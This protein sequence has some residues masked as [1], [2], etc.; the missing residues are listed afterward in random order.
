MLK[1]PD[2]EKWLTTVKLE[3]D[4]L[5]KMG[6]Y[7]VVDSD[8]IHLDVPMW[9]V[10]KIKRLLINKVKGKENTSSGNPP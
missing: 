7:E 3:F 6:W 8:D 4:T 10:Y 9:W 1:G 5:V 2:V